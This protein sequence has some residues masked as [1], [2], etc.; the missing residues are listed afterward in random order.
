[1]IFKQIF[2]CSLQKLGAI[3]YI[4]G[5]IHINIYIYIYIHILKIFFLKCRI[6]IEGIN[7]N[8]HY[9]S[10]NKFN[11]KKIYFIVCGGTRL[12]ECDLHSEQ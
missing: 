9:R 11:L 4:S 7:N 2:I 10:M 1:M 3:I 6:S 12:I 8:Y 5:Q